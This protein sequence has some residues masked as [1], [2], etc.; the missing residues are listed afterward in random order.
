MLKYVAF[1]LCNMS[2]NLIAPTY[3]LCILFFYLMYTS[4]DHIDKN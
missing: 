3:K 2:S 4:I 1:N